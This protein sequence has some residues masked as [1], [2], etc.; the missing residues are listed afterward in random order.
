MGFFKRG[1]PL[2]LVVEDEA[3]IADSIDARLYLAGYEIAVAR[4]GKEGVEKARA[5]LPDLMVLDVMMPKVDGFE[6]CRIVKGE[7]KTKKIPVLMLTALQSMGDIDRAF[8]VGANDYLSKPFTN[9]RLLAK[10][11]KLLTKTD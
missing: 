4:N 1:K 9:E 11:K 7:E 2:I 3:D 6:V 8:E 5:L 10:V